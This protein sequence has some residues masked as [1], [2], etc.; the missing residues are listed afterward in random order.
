[1]L[2]I[3]VFSSQGIGLGQD[4]LGVLIGFPAFVDLQL[5][6]EETLALAKEEGNGLVVIVGD[7]FPLADPVVA[8]VTIGLLIAGEVA[9]LSPGNDLSAPLAVQEVLLVAGEAVE[10]SFRLPGIFPEEPGAACLAENGECLTAVGTEDGFVHDIQISL[11]RKKHPRELLVPGGVGPWGHHRFRRPGRPRESWMVSCS[12]SS[13]LVRAMAQTRGGRRA[14]S[15]LSGAGE[16]GSSK[17]ITS[18]GNDRGTESSSEGV[19][20]GICRPWDVSRFN[21]QYTHGITS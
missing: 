9:S 4:F 20:W 14:G 12:C 2:G 11:S 19:R 6:A 13:V 8:V 1:M 10:V 17:K 16:M 15:S 3:G 21:E 7:D 5:H 18:Q